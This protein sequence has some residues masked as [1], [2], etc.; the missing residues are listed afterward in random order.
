MITG[1]AGMGI[2]GAFQMGGIGGRCFGQVG[3][4]SP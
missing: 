2:H 4:F 3:F 1:G